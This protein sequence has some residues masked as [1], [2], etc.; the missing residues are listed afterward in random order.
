MSMSMS[1]STRLDDDEW[2]SD[3]DGGGGEERSFLLPTRSSVRFGEA[4]ARASVRKVGREAKD[5][6]E[7]MS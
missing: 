5:G 4:S 6:C 1:R 7:V 3:G 2:G